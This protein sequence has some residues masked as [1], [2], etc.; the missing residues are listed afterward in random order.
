MKILTSGKYYGRKESEINVNQ[1]ILSEYDYRSARTDWHY[2]ENPYFMYLLQGNVYD[3]NKKVMTHC[4]S[5]SLI[6]HNWQ[7]THYNE[8][9][10]TQAR[11][12]HLEFP[13]SWFEQKKL[14]S[15]LWEGS[16]LIN[17]PTSH[18]LLAKLYFEF[19]CQDVYSNISIELLM[20][21]LC[22]T[23]EKNEFY[24]KE[25]QPLWINSLRQILNEDSE[26]LNLKLLSN[27]LGVH[28]V[29]ISRAV[30]KYFGSSLGD[31]IRQQK[32]KKA[33]SYIFSKNY[34][35]TE[36][37]HLCGFSD[38]SHFTRTFKLYLNKTPSQFSKQV[39]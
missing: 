8:K 39:F 37:A 27:Q 25:K 16:Q 34:S 35:L 24:E 23:I 20:L 30:P 15:N 32:I 7:E 36:I 10:T 33:L 26:N 12:F 9:A 4:T 13:R 2:H 11:G 19:R 22:E 28:P 21:Q 3:T 5:G 14:D 17:N 1:L 29:H 6:F 38:Q 18:Y 31:Y